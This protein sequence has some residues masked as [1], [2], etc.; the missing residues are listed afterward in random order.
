M[1]SGMQEQLLVLIF[2]LYLMAAFLPLLLQGRPK[3]SLEFGCFF[4][5]AAGLL[6]LVLGVGALFSPEMI[7][8][9]LGS[10]LPGVQF[11]I[12]MDR[13]SGFFVATICLVTSLVSLYSLGY[14]KLY[15]RENVAWWSFC[16]NIFVM[17]M[18]LVVMVTNA[19]TFLVFWEIMTLASYFLVTF[20][21]R[22]HQVRKAGF[23]YIVMTHIGTVFII[24][25]FL[26]MFNGIGG[27]WDFSA[28][29]NNS[30]GLSD[31]TKTL[32]FISAL[33]GFGIKAGIV[34][35][36]IW[37]PL[38]HPAAPSN[39]SAVMS[40]VML[41]TAIYGL[42]RLVLDILGPGPVWWGG[43]VLAVGVISAII[44]VLYALMEQDLKRLLA[45]SSVENIG[46]IF[47]GIGTSL[48]FYAWSMPVP[49]AVALAAGLF[50][51]LNHAVFKS[52]LFLGTGSI[53]YTTHTR[54]MEELGGLIKRMPHTSL[55][56][57]VGAVSI[58]AIPPFSGFASEYQ[59]YQSLLGLSYSKISG[60]WSVSGIL[61]CAALALTGALAAACFVKAFGI[62]FLAL[63]RTQKAT[64]AREVPWGMRL[65]MAPLGILCLVP[66]VVP[67]AVMNSLTPIAGQLLPGP[68]LP[69]VHTFNLNLV[70]VLAVTMAVLYGTGKLL[71]AKKVRRGETWGCGIVLNAAMEYTAASFSQPV[72]RV[73]RSL[74][75]PERKIK[76]SYSYH[77]YF[78]YRIF[79]EEH[80]R[81]VFMIY[82]YSP[83]R[84]M[85]VGISK[86]W[87]RIQSGNIN[88]YLGYIFITLVILLAWVR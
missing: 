39:V 30:A 58:S 45:F 25:A 80:I 68:V 74:L 40:G 86:K 4:G 57:L 81:P 64:E 61:A 79:F 23:S 85:A 1:L 26:M 72:R 16:Y 13:L 10:I 78:N 53:Y 69:R 38:A 66:G 62:S 15:L 20:E 55:L 7:G 34:P 70:V 11:K 56:F 18:V 49:A 77:P 28:L 54:D 67:G 2:A 19:I 14:M 12:S 5:F 3:L 36:H 51:V 48:V 71:G 52:L 22:H 47:M 43:L 73:Y 63:P 17:S 42:V 41:K 37:L 76:I 65:S 60:F 32:V 6:G 59:I 82:L 46:I 29:S 83:L 44:G 84:S 35:L 50:H 21:Y 31:V 8:V 88:M 75:Q 33:I 24:S 27:S 9:N 87:Q